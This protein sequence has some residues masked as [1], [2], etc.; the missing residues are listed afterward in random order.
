MKKSKHK[1]KINQ[2]ILYYIKLCF[3][4]II[5]KQKIERENYRYFYKDIFIFDNKHKKKKIKIIYD[6]FSFFM[7]NFDLTIIKENQNMWNFSC[8][9]KEYKN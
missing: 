4:V 5:Y 9:F 1:V 7:R 8:K 2:N 6:N 3:F